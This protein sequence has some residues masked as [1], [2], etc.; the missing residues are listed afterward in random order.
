MTN[1]K[2]SHLPMI[3]NLFRI[4]VLCSLFFSSLVIASERKNLEWKIGSHQTV[5]G[6][7]I[8]QISKKNKIPI[9]LWFHGGMNSN[10]TQK[11]SQAYLAI[12]P[13]LKKPF[14]VAST[15]AWK[16]QNWLSPVSIETIDILLDSLVQYYQGNPKDI[17]AV[18]IS[19]GN[20]GILNY[21]LRGKYPLH[22]RILI[23]SFLPAIFSL[24]DY[25]ELSVHPKFKMG[26]WH[27]FQGKIDRLFPFGQVE[28][29]LTQWKQT[30]PHTSLHIFPNGLHDWSYYDTAASVEIEGILKK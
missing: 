3:L 16:N 23:S 13:H 30:F 14:L 2:G 7:S 1:K 9:L 5:S 27:F 21:T 10:H 24:Q 11:G 28:P 17:R 22:T 20:F 18:G 15:S 19:D 12:L 6:V 29:F 4:V 25:P 26:S 8:P